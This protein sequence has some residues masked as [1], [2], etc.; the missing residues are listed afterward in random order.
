MILG[1]PCA[2][3]LECDTGFCVDGVCCNSAC[4][5]GC[6]TC[7]LPQA[8]GV[9]SAIAAGATP[10]S[11]SFCPREAPSSCGLDGTCNGAKACRTHVQGTV[12]KPGLCSSMMATGSAI[13]DGKGT[14]AT[15]ASKACAPYVCGV[16]ACIA[17]CA[18]DMQCEPAAKCLAKTC[19]RLDA[20]QVTSTNGLVLCNQRTP[21]PPTETV[22][23][24]VGT[25]PPGATFEWTYS[26]CGCVLSGFTASTLPVKNNSSG[27]FT[28]RWVD[29]QTGTK[30]AVSETVY[31]TVKTCTPN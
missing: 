3:D 7:A 30:S 10:R 15:P 19:F 28:V 21:A 29:P 24:A 18:N 17:E 31:V 4:T 11:Q 25:F 12:C 13:C 6:S 23:Q 26:A 14:C 22:L 20:P 2:R 1:A 27:Y 8:K 16:D 9:C 5:N